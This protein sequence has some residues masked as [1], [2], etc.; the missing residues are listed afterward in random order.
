MKGHIIPLAPIFKTLYSALVL[1]GS[2]ALLAPFPI[3]DKFR[4]VL[5]GEV[6]VGI[7][8]PSKHALGRQ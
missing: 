3:S 8:P 4:D 7:G 1:A 5:V 2:A 6:S